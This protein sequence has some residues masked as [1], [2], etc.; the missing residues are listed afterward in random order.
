MQI[1]DL[2]SATGATVETIRYYEREGLLLAP[3]RQG[4]GYRSYSQTHVEQLAFIRHCRALGMPLA[5]IRQLLAAMNAPAD[6]C[7]TTDDLIEAE[8]ARVRARLISLQALEKQLL[9]LLTACSGPQMQD[10]C[11]I[12]QELVAAA[13]G[14]ACVCHAPRFVQ[15]ASLSS[16]NSG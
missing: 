15:T 10:G 14:E 5:G 3:Q 11:G 2:A 7:E 13:K 12:L 16:A 9:T 6:Y 4:N 8:L 1:K